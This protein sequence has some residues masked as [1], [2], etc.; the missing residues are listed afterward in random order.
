MRFVLVR[1]R[2]PN[3]IGAAARAMANFG[4]DDLVVVEPWEPSW[5][6]ARA[7]VGASHVLDNA[8]SVSTLDEAIAESTLVAA[9]TAATRRRIGRSIGPR[10]FAGR[11]AGE[12]IE[13]SRVAVLFGNEKRGLTSAEID[14]AHF[15]VVIPTRSEQPSMNLSHAVAIVA[16]E[17]ARMPVPGDGPLQ[18]SR[19]RG[20]ARATVAE[21]ERL[22]ASATEPEDGSSR[23][24]RPTAA[25]DRLRQLLLRSNPSTADIQLLFTLLK[26]AS[27]NLSTK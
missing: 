20:E 19:M 24:Q 27:D 10:E 21:V 17:M 14:R 22:V 4:F 16:W 2:D 26:R 25:A 23:L 1:P 13:R 11:V 8:R 3:N 18:Y 7:A 9:T 15:V 12:G 6:E 5:R